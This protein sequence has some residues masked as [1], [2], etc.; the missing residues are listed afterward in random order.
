MKGRKDEKKREKWSNISTII[1]KHNIAVLAVQEC[2]LNQEETTKLVDKA[3]RIVV[4]SSGTSTTKEGVAFVLNKELVNCEY[5]VDEIIPGR[6]MRIQMRYPDDNGLDIINVYAPNPV[7]EKIEFFEKLYEQLEKLDL[8][9]PIILGD[10]NFVEYEIDRYPM[11]EDDM[12]IV[13]KFNRIKDKYHLLDGWRIY[14]PIER[15]YTLFTKGNKKGA[16]SRIDRIYMHQDL[17]TFAYNWTFLTSM[18]MSDHDIVMVEILKKKLPYIGDGL[19][20]IDTDTLESPTFQKV[21]RKI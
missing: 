16:M 7:P 1:R 3:P 14:N 11:H 20:R 9:E 8:R 21:A 12:R 15:A 10:F 13:N 19:Q 2:H 17:A 5:I 18:K 4:Y 6:A